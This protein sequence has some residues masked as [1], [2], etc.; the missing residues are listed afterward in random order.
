MFLTGAFLLA[1]F[2]FEHASAKPS[3]VPSAAPNAVVVPG[4]I[5]SLARDIRVER[6]RVRRLELLAGLMADVKKR[7][8]DLP[9]DISEEDVPR[10]ELL[11]ELNILLSSLKPE[12][13][14][15]ATCPNVL[16]AMKQMTN[17]SGLD[18]GLITS[19]SRLALD[20]VKSVCAP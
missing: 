1:I 19:P 9:D 4:E 12:M 8:G 3:S 15:P 2:S 10:V 5:V 6:S 16:R 17:P 11:Y 13:I 14:N 20:V 7:V 18:E